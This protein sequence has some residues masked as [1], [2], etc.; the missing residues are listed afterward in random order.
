MTSFNTASDLLLHRLR[1]TAQASPVSV[2]RLIL[3]CDVVFGSPSARCQGTGICKIIAREEGPYR[4]RHCRHTVAFASKGQSGAGLSLYFFREHLCSSLMRLHFRH[5]YIQVGESC[6]L[7]KKLVH[8]L[9]LNVQVITPG[10]YRLEES[11]LYYRLD[12]DE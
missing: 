9:E 1:D 6:R 8:Q 2:K 7:P 5:G 4:N 11:N 3:H 12:F 10:Q